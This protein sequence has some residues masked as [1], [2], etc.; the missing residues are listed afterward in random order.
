MQERKPCIASTTLNQQN[1]ILQFLN[2]ISL[3]NCPKVWTLEI[4]IDVP[5]VCHLCCCRLTNDHSRGR[6]AIRN[7]Y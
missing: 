3:E 1:V 7:G 5:T 2:K 4:F 6:V